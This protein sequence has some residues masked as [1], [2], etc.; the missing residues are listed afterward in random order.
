[1]VSKPGI[2]VSV[3]NKGP[4]DLQAHME[5]WKHKKAVR[6][7]MI[8]AKVTNFLLQW[9]ANDAIL[10]AEGAFSF[11]FKTLF[12]DSEIACKF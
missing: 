6:G 5:C 3:A 12:S 7:K 2:Y 9:E 10:V 11:L 8:L 1:L 4:L